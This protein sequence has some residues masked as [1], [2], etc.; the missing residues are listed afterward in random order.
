MILKRPSINRIAK[1]AAGYPAK[2]L[3]EERKIQL[4]LK[5]VIPNAHK[6]PLPVKKIYRAWQTL[7]TLLSTEEITTLLD[8]IRDTTLRNPPQRK[9]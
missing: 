2:L 1:A 9:S 8:N 7:K 4:L 5:I 6:P 3:P